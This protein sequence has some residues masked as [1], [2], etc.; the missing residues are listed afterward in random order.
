MKIAFDD[1]AATRP[2]V[3]A[4]FDGERT[5]PPGLDGAMADLLAPLLTGLAAEQ[6]R[7]LLLPDAGGGL[8]RVI[9]LTGAMASP[10]AAEALGA[11]IAA[12]PV[13]DGQDTVDLIVPAG[14]IG[15]ASCRERV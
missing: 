2:L 14:Q 5:V 8:R 7:D 13:T 15:R 11:R 10:L 9:V 4:L 6:Q 12:L 1:G 3:L